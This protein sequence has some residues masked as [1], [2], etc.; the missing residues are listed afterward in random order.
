GDPAKRVVLDELC[1]RYPPGPASPQPAARAIREQRAILLD[2]V[3][4]EVLAAHTVDRPHRDLMR[5]LEVRS[6]LAVPLMARGKMLGAMS[7][8]LAAR[9]YGAADVFFAEELA[10]RAA[11][12]IDNARLFA[13]AEAARREAEE[14]SRAKDEFLA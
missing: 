6:H 5:A 13:Q 3:D 8:G 4:E 11:L 10:T 12:A 2:E 1:R 7:L 14:A 9:R